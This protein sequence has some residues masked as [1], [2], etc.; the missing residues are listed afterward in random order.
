MDVSLGGMVVMAFRCWMCLGLD[1]M[2]VVG[3]GL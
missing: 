2:V 1:E 3:D